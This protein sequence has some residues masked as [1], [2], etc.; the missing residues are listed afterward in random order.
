MPLSM[1]LITYPQADGLVENFNKTLRAMIAKH[2][3]KYGTNWDDH[4]EALLVV[5][6]KDH[7]IPGSSDS[8]F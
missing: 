4:L 7:Q 6:P 2:A 1:E 3:A 5:C 8:L